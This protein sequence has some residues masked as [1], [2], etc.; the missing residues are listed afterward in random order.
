VQW[1]PLDARLRR[2][3]VI[4]PQAPRCKAFTSPAHRQQH[5]G[6]ITEVHLA[7]GTGAGHPRRTDGSRGRQL[8]PVRGPADH[9]CGL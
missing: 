6:P 8:P 9:P 1:A 7:G 5:T 4:G 2:G 3:D